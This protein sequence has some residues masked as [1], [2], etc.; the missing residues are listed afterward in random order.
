L[1]AGTFG[2][3]YKVQGLAI[4]S[5]QVSTFVQ[6]VSNTDPYDPQFAI[7]AREDIETECQNLRDITSRA[8]EMGRE[9][10]LEGLQE[11]PIDVTYEGQQ[12]VMTG[13]LYQGDL[14]GKQGEMSVGQ[15]LKG[16]DPLLKGLAFIQDQGLVHVDIKPQNIFVDKNE[17]GEFIF[18]LADFGGARWEKDLTKHKQG[19]ITHTRS[20]TPDPRLETINTHDAVCL[21]R[22]GTFQMGVT[23]FQVLSGGSLPYPLTDT[24]F[25]NPRGRFNEEA[26]AGYPQDVVDFI[27]SM[28]DRDPS[29]RPTGDQIRQGWQRIVETHGGLDSLAQN[30]QATRETGQLLASAKQSLQM[31]GKY[32]G[33]MD[34]ATCEEQLKYTQT[35]GETFLLRDSDNYGG[36]VISGITKG[37]KFV[38]MG[39]NDPTIIAGLKEGK[40]IFQIINEKLGY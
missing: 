40:R 35:F 9:D 27:K 31:Y 30:A 6:K 15:K 37:G 16:M 2:T 28:V 4:S 34:R 38:H 22:I 11:A 25:Q 12:G 7:K 14:Q 20:Y 5:L 26:L 3:A 36:P 24:G 13:K 18:R 1:G 21:H 23:L 39:L 32:V 8:K 29:K 19:S 33:K 10:A 17:R